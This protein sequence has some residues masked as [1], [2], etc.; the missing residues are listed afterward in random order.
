MANE[1]YDNDL[2]ELERRQKYPG[3]IETVDALL[4]FALTGDKAKLIAIKAVRD[5]VDAEKPKK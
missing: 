3:I 5:A 2:L 1:K 4:E